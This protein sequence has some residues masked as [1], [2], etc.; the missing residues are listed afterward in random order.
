MK[1]IVIRRVRTN[2]PRPISTSSKKAAKR[3]LSYDA[4]KKFNPSMLELGDISKPCQEIEAITA[5]FDLSGFTRFC[6]QVDS[7]LTI[8]RFFNEF[9]EW[10]FG[11]VREKLTEREHGKRVSVWAEFPILAKFLGD[12]LLLLWNAQTLTEA[13]ICRLIA[14]LYDICYAYKHEFYP[15]M[16]MVVNKP[17]NVLR[18]GVARGKVFSV[19]NGKDYVG[20]C[21]NNATRLS[22]V[23]NLSF[24]FPHS[25]FQVQEHMPVEYSD[26]FV[27]KYVSIRGVGDHE[28]VWVVKEEFNRLPEKHKDLFRSLEPVLT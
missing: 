4:V 22:Q 2:R 12:G 5:V 14:I 7:Y 11:I 25:G 1:K 21:I 10:F 19:G 16:K 8:P 27:P 13:K 18:C 28:L 24:C 23:G 17:P 9:L 3:M 15:K 6:N 26:L 20:H